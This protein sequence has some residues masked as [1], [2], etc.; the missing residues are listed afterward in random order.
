MTRSLEAST[1]FRVCMSTQ[2]VFIDLAHR[3]TSGCLEVSH[4]CQDTA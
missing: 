1:K 2:P 3:P 4:A